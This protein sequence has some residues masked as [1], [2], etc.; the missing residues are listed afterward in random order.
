MIFPLAITFDQPVMPILPI[1]LKC[2]SIQGSLVSSRQNLRELFV[3][4]AQ[5]KITAPMVKYPLSV[6]GIET[7]M[8]ELRDG[9]VR[10]RAVLVRDLGF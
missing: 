1:N 6:Q 8:Q 10:Y 7:A 9:K 5:K 2:V 4:A 3:F